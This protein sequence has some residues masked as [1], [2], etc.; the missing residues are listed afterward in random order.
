MINIEQRPL[1]LTPTKVPHVYNFISSNSGNTDF[2]YVIDVYVDTLTS[3]PSK[4][5]RLLVS[6]NSYGNGIVDVSRIIENYVEGN[7]RSEQPQY[8][9]S[10]TTGNTPYSIITNVSG[11]STS[12]AFNTNINYEQK[13]HVRDYRLL[14]GEQYT[15]TAGTITDISTASTTPASIILTDTESVVA[16]Y[17]GINQVNWYGAG[18]GVPQGSSLNKGVSITHING[19]LVTAFTTT[20]VDGSYLAASQP[21]DGDVLTITERF[22]GCFIKYIWRDEPPFVLGWFLSV[23]KT[24]PTGFTN[25][26]P[27]VIIWPGTKEKQGSYT[28]YVNNNLY[29]DT[30][31]P[32]D[33]QDYWEVKKYR[34]SGGTISDV[35]P[36]QF[37]TTA[38]DK[39]YSFTDTTLGTVT[40]ARRRKHH[41][42]CPVVVS[43]FNGYLSE[44]A[45]F[46]FIN[47]IENIIVAESSSQ[48]SN[49]SSVQ[50]V[51]D[52]G[53]TY[54]GI[55]DAENTIKYLT[56]IRPD[57][58]G[59]KLAVYA[60][61]NGLNEPDWQNYGVSE[62]LEYY[63]ENNDC[64]S[65]PVHLLFLNRQ[66]V[67]DTY[68]F[69]RKALE[70]TD[71]TRETYAKGGI[72]D[73][74][75]YT[76]LSSQRRDV[77]YNQ[78]VKQ[79]MNV[80]TWFLTDNDK[81]IVEDL[82]LSPEVYIILNHNWMGKTEKSYN[83]YLLPVTINTNSI[84][85]YKN[86]Y[87]KLTTYSFKFQYT[88]INLYEAQG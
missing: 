40:R 2:R 70:Q 64:L 22:S 45:D 74:P 19:G 61:N 86:R 28:P 9:S 15:T 4:I 8:T 30:T 77:I 52:N 80:D 31:D 12:N 73:R 14:V 23:A 88:P 16:S 57:L 44:Y 59:G 54:T 29:W 33:Q 55:T 47:N 68:T 58:A 34:M 49:Y 81:R 78:N 1:P 27:T 26:P 42:E 24:C 10:G 20:E 21:S 72:G 17:S 76:S 79:V 25:N 43:Y 36:S 63:M 46:E 32:S 75:L 60:S 13:Y 39:L 82:F 62:L 37:L 18:A 69:D 41:P 11:L 53:I 71:I 65:D 56:Q 38:G 35:E 51:F 83:P 84:L 7:A 87:T 66:G 5:S 48:T 50:K 6:P 3:N 85:E 67:W